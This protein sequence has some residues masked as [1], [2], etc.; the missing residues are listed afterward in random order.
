MELLED[1]VMVPPVLDNRRRLA[2]GSSLPA[3]AEDPSSSALL[4]AVTLRFTAG[5][6]DSVATLIGTLSEDVGLTDAIVGADEPLELEAPP[7]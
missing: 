6:S 4:L 5:I 1:D 7:S 2:F 3:V